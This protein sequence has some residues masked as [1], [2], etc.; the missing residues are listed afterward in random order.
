[1]LSYLFFN[2]LIASLTVNFF[3][4]PVNNN[5][6]EF[7]RYD[8]GSW[9]SF[10]IISEGIIVATVTSEKIFPSTA[11]ET[12]KRLDIPDGNRKFY[13]FDVAAACAGYPLAISLANSL[14]K[15]G[16]LQGPIAAVA[17][18]RLSKMIDHYDINSP[19]FGDGAGAIVF[20]KKKKEFWY[21]INRI[22][23]WW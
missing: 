9:I 15:S 7:W 1:M 14:L 13:A 8:L 19:L 17:S 3:L 22:I 20:S 6:S 11:C 12:Q 23:F 18:E 4:K 10:I 21:N 5:L 16:E 2:S